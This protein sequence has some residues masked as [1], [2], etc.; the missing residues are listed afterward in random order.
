MSGDHHCMLNSGTKWR[1]E[2]YAESMQ[3]VIIKWNGIHLKNKPMLKNTRR[4]AAENITVSP[5]SDFPV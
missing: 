3:K 5:S 2:L 4:M 1:G